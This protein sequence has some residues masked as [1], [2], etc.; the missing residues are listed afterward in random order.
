ML[1]VPLPPPEGRAAILTA[2]TRGTPLA[3][4]VDLHAIGTDGAATN[5][6]GADLAALVREACVLSLKV[7]KTVLNYKPSYLLLG[8]Q[9]CPS[10]ARSALVRKACVLSLK[11]QKR[12]E[13]QAVIE[14]RICAD[15][16]TDKLQR[17]GPGCS[18]ARPACCS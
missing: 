14:I 9:N 5:Y 6:S 3:P 15:G 10:P 13:T 16:E 11:V 2:L 7:R 18:C 8:R 17:R 1:Y 4:D 12:I